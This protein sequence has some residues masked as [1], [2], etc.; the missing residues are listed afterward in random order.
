MKDFLFGLSY[1]AGT[2]S[3]ILSLFIG[4]S[5]AVLLFVML[6]FIIGQTVCF[7]IDKKNRVPGFILF[8]LVFSFLILFS[9]LHYLDTVMHYEEFAVDWRDEYKFWLVSQDF[10]RYSSLSSIFQESYTAY[11]LK[12]LSGYALY[13][14]SLAYLAENISDGNHLLLQFLGTSLWGGLLSLLLYKV[15]LI[16]MPKYESFRYVLVFSIFSVLF[17]FSFVLLRDILIAF[18]YLWVFY[19]LLKKF[20]LSGIF[21]VVFIILIVWQLRM[22]HALFLVVF[23]M[24][25]IYSKYS[26]NK[27]V[28]LLMAIFAGT[29]LVFLFADALLQ[30]T[31]TIDRYGLRGETTALDIEDSLGKNLYFLPPVIKQIAIFIVSQIRPFPSWNS[32]EKSSNIYSGI[33]NLLPVFYTF[34]WFIILYTLLKIYL[35]QKIYRTISKELNLL[36]IIC[37]GFLFVISQG[38]SDAR[39]IMYVYPFI[40]LIYAITQTKIIPSLRR[41]VTREAISLFIFLN[42]IYIFLKF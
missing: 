20:S 27:I 35:K 4:Q 30:A 36:L 32:L 33:V 11:V 38:A 9:C 1:L 24:Y 23:L 2:F 8:N 26:Y 31:L 5:F 3:I 16:F 15:F 28:V 40:F 29:I 17:A 12:D 10:S 41:R 7:S 13:I 37:V 18:C 39:R 42:L 22:E 14:G 21:K 25:Y 6:F 19:I 34:Y